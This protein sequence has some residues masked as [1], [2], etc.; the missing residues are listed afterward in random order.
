M[1]KALIVHGG[2][3]GHTPKECAALFA[4]KLGERGFKVEVSDT[5][6]AFRNPK[7]TA[8]LSLI[9]PSWPCCTL[10]P[11]QSK[12]AIDLVLGGVGIAGFHGGMCDAFRSNI[13][14]QWMTGGQFLA[15]PDNLKDYTIHIV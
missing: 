5:L 4:T 9:V 2:W 6:D 11:E 15:H 8:D 10:T 13:D 3:D 7:L 12:G 1:K 14:W